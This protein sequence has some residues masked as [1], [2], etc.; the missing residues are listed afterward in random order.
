MGIPYD[1]PI[2]YDSPVPYNGIDPVLAM[3]RSTIAGIVTV[4]QLQ[5]G[6]TVYRLSSAE[7]GDSGTHWHDARLTGDIAYSRGVDTLFWRQRESGRNVGAGNIEAINMDGALDALAVGPV[8]DGIA[9]VFRVAAD[10]PMSEAVQVATSIVTD[11][12]GRGEETLRIVTG[13]L[14]TLLDV[15][16][17][18]VLYETGDADDAVVG[19]SRPVAIG[20]PL[21]CPITL[22]DGVDYEYDVHDSDAF[23]IATVRDSGA[24][25]VVGTDPGYGYRIA[26]PPV[27][28]I[29]LLQ[30]PE[31]RVVADVSVTSAASESIIG[32]AEGDFGTDLADWDVI[33]DIT[34]G[35]AA[36]AVWDAGAAELTA[37]KTGYPGGASVFARLRFPTTLVAGQ[38]YSW[39]MDV[40]ATCAHADGHEVLQVFFEPTSLLP[41]EYVT[42]ALIVATTADALSGEFTAP[43]AGRL[44]ISAGAAAYGG[45]EGDIA[46]QIDNV[47]LSRVAS[48][49]TVADVIEQLLARAGISSDR[50]DADSIDALRAAR[51]WPVSYWTDSATT[52]KEVMRWVLD[53]IYGWYY[54]TPDGR[55]AF[56]YLVPPEDP[57]DDSVLTITESMLDGGI[58]V[59]ADLAPG[60]STT[61]AGQRNWY[62]YGP[63]EFVDA[64]VDADRAMLAA[65]YRVRCTATD[66]VGLDLR[67][68]QGA[69]VSA[70][71]ES[72][73]ATLLDDPAN[74]QT[75]ADYLSVLYPA[76]VPRKHF[77]VPVLMSDAQVAAL[78]PGAKVTLRRDRFGCNDGRPLRFINIDARVGDTTC[79]LRCWGSGDA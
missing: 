60:L 58:E 69:A 44:V 14:E 7:Y 32:S 73:I 48:G 33:T 13:G 65:D 19:R 62:R 25:L 1:A 56:G 47:R 64:V 40:D 41:G 45:D 67:R 22:I 2:P 10:A 78:K 30:L 68:R 66:P 3:P 27:H 63:S 8:S 52:V 59:S 79:V 35:G 34:G 20:N 50:I 53:S 4:V 70:V 71:S 16:L 76:D 11:L 12:E 38:R 42:L 75:A 55:F 18:S 9:R 77:G 57:A 28:G 49:G 23:S 21:S 46:A 61:V 51:P 72:G 29:E 26:D 24:V 74:I 54:I 17:Q 43:A 15:P 6:S 39:S 37:S 36:A 31:G 5:L